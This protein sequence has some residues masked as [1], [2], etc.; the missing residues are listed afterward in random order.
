MK[1]RNGLLLLLAISVSPVTLR[2]EP[3]P[4]GA[5]GAIPPDFQITS[6]ETLNPSADL[7][8]YGVVQPTYQTATDAAHTKYQVWKFEAT[9]PAKARAVAGKLLADLTLSPGVTQGTLDQRVK[10]FPLMTVPSGGSYTGFISGSTACVISSDNATALQRFLSASPLAGTDVATQLDYPPV[11][12]PWDRYDLDTRSYPFE[13]W[14][15]PMA[16]LYMARRTQEQMR[17]FLAA[18]KDITA[19]ESPYC[20][21]PFSEG[22]W[23]WYHADY[24]PSAVA[25]WKRTLRDD[26]HLGLDEVSAM[27]ARADR[28]F[29]S[30][31]EILPPELA[32]FSGLPGMVK[33]LEGDWSV[34]PET[35]KK[36]GETEQWWQAD[37]A[38]PPWETMHLPGGGPVVRLFPAAKMG[39]AR[40]P[41]DRRGTCLRP[42]ALP[43]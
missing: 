15:N 36:Q 24:S 35:A 28:S 26:Q 27:Y 8:G 23:Y 14:F 3:A 34:R 6:T 22:E 7:R 39:R 13:S 37:L 33:N 18:D 25:D 10:K 42:A 12:D 17:A 16:R 2:A 29:H 41:N 19:W 20:E 38:A 4:A 1:I 5:L 43:S 31:D 32:T 9:D 21:F 40:L 11:L 30:W